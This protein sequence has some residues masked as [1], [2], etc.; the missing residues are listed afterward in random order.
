MI[1]GQI[2]GLSV[3]AQLHVVEELKKKLEI[4]KIPHQLVMVVG[5]VGD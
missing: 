2:G 4:A 1:D 3:V 5:D